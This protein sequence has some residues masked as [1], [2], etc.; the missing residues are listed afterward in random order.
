[1]K[2]ILK[3][4]KRITVIALAM[5]MIVMIV[6][7]CS[8]DGAAVAEGEL[9]AH[10]HWMHFPWGYSGQFDTDTE[11]TQAMMDQFTEK[12]PGVSFTYEAIPWDNWQAVIS[13]SIA[14]GAP[15]D[16]FAFGSWLAGNYLDH[17]W[18]ID[19]FL[20]E[21]DW[22]DF[23]PA[24]MAGGYFDGQHYVWP[25]MN[26]GVN[27]VV[28]VDIANERGVT[29]PDNPAGDWTMA[30]FLEAAQLM[31]FVNDN[32]DQVFGGFALYGLDPSINWGMTS[33]VG[34]FGGSVFDD[35]LMY[36][37][38]NTPE[39][40]AALHWMLKLQDELQVVPPGGAGLT[41]DQ[42]REMFIMQRTA[43]QINSGDFA[44]W[45]GMAMDDGIID[46]PFEFQ[47]VQFPLVEGRETTVT[48]IG[49]TGFIVFRQQTDDAYARRDAAMAFCSMLTSV[50]ELTIASELDRLVP[51][52]QSTAHLYSLY[53]NFVASSR[54]KIFFNGSVEESFYHEELT[55]LYQ[56][57]LNRSLTPEEAVRN[58]DETLNETIRRIHGN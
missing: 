14:A 3:K 34:N 6:V 12:H 55:A 30:E 44:M 40:I 48:R 5:C 4:C 47:Y 18:P 57:V 1:M 43:M 50:E 29:L 9:S 42:T 13:T 38:M 35:D 15:P 37:N 56:S 22:E 32:G 23:I 46:E 26:Q 2:A 8:D 19:D 21:E 39:T 53:E 52:R 31:T 36:M 24:A 27:L 16:V 20:T 41:I 10:I 45:L 51:V 17:L 54:G 58:F 33:V 11:W 25:W 49:P 7:A 28:N